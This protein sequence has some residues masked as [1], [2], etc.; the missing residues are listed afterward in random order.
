M[1][2]P[3][4]SRLY[5]ALTKLR[6]MWAGWRPGRRSTLLHS[7]NFPAGAVDACRTG[8]CHPAR[9]QPVLSVASGNLV[10][11]NRCEGCRMIAWN[12]PKQPARGVLYNVW[13]WW[14]VLYRQRLGSAQLGRGLVDTNRSCIRE[15][16]AAHGPQRA[17]GQGG[18]QQ[19]RLSLQCSHSEHGVVHCWVA[20]RGLLGQQELQDP[21]FATTCYRP[22]CSSSSSSSTEAHLGS[23]Q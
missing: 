23:I 9:R 19:R 20:R 1:R 3:H 11:C 16:L 22:A 2:L 6:P 13:W 15:E 21:D 4:V 5:S 14:G 7:P 18:C 17:A 10:Q 8:G 12:I